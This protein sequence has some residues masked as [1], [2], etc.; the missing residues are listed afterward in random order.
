MDDR[1]KA[2]A[3]LEEAARMP[4]SALKVRTCEEGARL[5]DLCNDE[6]LGF[7]ARERIVRAAAFCGEP[8]SMLVAFAWI[9]AI[10]DRNPQ[11]YPE[12]HQTWKYKWAINQITK[13]PQISRERIDAAFDDMTMRYTRCGLSLRAV[14]H[15]RESA[16]RETGDLAAAENWHQL[17]VKAPKD[18]TQDCS[19]CERD[20]EV[21]YL[22][23]NGR[24][25]EGLSHAEPILSGRMRCGSVPENTLARFACYLARAGR[26]DEARAMARQG[27]EHLDKDPSSLGTTGEL[28]EA[29]ALCGDREAG[30]RLLER[31]LQYLSGGGSPSAHFWYLYGARAL[32]AA[33]AAH[34]HAGVRKLRLPR[35]HA[36]YKA[37]G[38]YH[39]A[40]LITWADDRLN[41]I[42]AA[43]DM[44]NG[45]NTFASHLATLRAGKP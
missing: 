2:E 34:S 4:D 40:S 25:D 22:V 3:L 18:G 9:L 14:Y 10:C 23:R 27:L 16:A 21:A 24:L 1:A 28:L 17:W 31:T 11:K 19:A 33:V 15:L 37:S 13:F 38:E 26:L 42:A 6:E 20:Q 35:A 7:R 39:L 12:R 5:A 45:N 44:R 41:S 32:L 43:F 36:E 29:L 30:L 8:E